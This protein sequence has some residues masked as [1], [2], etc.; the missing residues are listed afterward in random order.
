[1][2]LPAGVSVVGAHLDL[3][4]LCEER[5][6]RP[7]HVYAWIPKHAAV[8]EPWVKE[9]ELKYIRTFRHSSASLDKASGWSDTV[10][11]DTFQSVCV[12]VGLFVAFICLQVP[13]CVYTD[14]LHLRPNEFHAASFRVE[15][16][17]QIFDLNMWTSSPTAQWLFWCLLWYLLQLI[18]SYK[19]YKGASH[20]TLT[21]TPRVIS[22]CLW[23]RVC[24]ALHQV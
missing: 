23:R 17:F 22:K 9:T 3:D 20:I 19:Q 12:C 16:Y 21:H 5:A 7:A 10:L 1:M 14:R 24:S 4:W 18:Q 2:S 6:E 11:S 13:T 15:K 8:V